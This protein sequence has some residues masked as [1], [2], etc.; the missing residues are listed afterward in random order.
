[1]NNPDELLNVL[2][3]LS[4]DQKVDLF[5]TVANQD[6]TVGIML[7]DKME[8]KEDD[9]L[10][11]ELFNHFFHHD[12]QFN[13][14]EHT[15]KIKEYLEE[16]FVNDI[17]NVLS[18]M[19]SKFDYYLLEY[20]V[21][22]NILSLENFKKLMSYPVQESFKEFW[23]VKLC[24]EIS[25]NEF[26]DE[27][28]KLVSENFFNLDDKRQRELFIDTDIVKYLPQNF[29]SKMASNKNVPKFA[30]DFIYTLLKNT[31]E[32]DEFLF[33]SIKNDL[34]KKENK[35][36]LN[37]LSDSVSISEISVNML[38]EFRKI[39]PFNLEAMPEKFSF[40]NEIRT[41]VKI[42]DG[43]ENLATFLDYCIK[44]QEKCIL[45][46][47]EIIAEDFNAF[48]ELK[49]FKNPTLLAQL[50]YVSNS[51]MSDFDEK[52]ILENMIDNIK[53]NEEEITL[54]LDDGFDDENTASPIDI[55]LSELEKHVLE[56]NL[57]TPN[58]RKKLKL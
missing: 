9:E 31:T 6:S 49:L 26:D 29:L 32:F 5:S 1:M 4:N 43:V 18:E 44:N 12:Y 3:L 54:F 58:T 27:A 37:H 11:Q 45:M 28:L 39:F 48:Y 47:E 42:L 55:V 2:N 30:S 21:D 40:I 10:R 38:I 15:Q 25:V 50:I 14:G 51:N 23:H 20:K 8:I 35:E 17:I 46:N 22:L 36:L 34:S 33:N 13:Q 41:I 7:L 24:S 56:F 16:F 19:K 53:K 57:S 52:L